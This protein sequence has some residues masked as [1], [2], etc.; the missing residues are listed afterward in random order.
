M[1]AFFTNAS[2]CVVSVMPV[3]LLY[4]CEFSAFRARWDHEAR[5]RTGAP[6]MWG[7]FE[8]PII[9]ARWDSNPR[10]SPRSSG[11]FQKK[12]GEKLFRDRFFPGFFCI[13]KKKLL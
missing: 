3:I 10:S 11:L 5:L 13:G 2:V 8:S 7:F 6:R 1:N 4:V 9:R 12:A